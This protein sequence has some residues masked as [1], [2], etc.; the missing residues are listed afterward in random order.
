MASPEPSVTITKALSVLLREVLRGAP[1]KN[2]FVLNPN[3]PGLLA[4]LDG[5]S[6]AA[7]SAQPGGRSSIAAH[8]HHLYYG[9]SLFNRWSRGEENPFADAN[10]SASWKH[11]H[12]SPEEWDKLRGMFRTEAEAWILAAE[13]PREWDRLTLTGTMASVVHLAYHLGAIRQLDASASG[14]KATD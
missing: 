12:V 7:A 1:A 5:L 4:T 6:A 9:L 3:D 2:T 8:V 14:P 10:F 11:Q 13:R